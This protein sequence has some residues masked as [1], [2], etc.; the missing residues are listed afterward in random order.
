MIL[1]ED[2]IND[3]QLDLPYERGPVVSDYMRNEPDIYRTRHL[4]RPVRTL[5]NDDIWRLMKIYKVKRT[6]TVRTYL[7]HARDIPDAIHTL[8]C[9]IRNC[10]EYFKP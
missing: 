7:H 8:D 3:F 4:P 10:R 9:L 6:H 1:P 2:K 5:T